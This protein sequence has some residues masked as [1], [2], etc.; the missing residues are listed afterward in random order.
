M[1]ELLRLMGPETGS[2]ALG[3]I[4]KAFPEVPLA[5]RVKVLS[6]YRQMPEAVSDPAGVTALRIASA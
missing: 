3:A 1:R 4:R 5:E 6:E 2:S